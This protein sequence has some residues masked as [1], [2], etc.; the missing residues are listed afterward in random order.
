MLATG[1]GLVFSGGT[2]DR[3]FRAFDATSGA[4]LWQFPTSSGVIG[5]PVSFTVDGKQYVAVQSGWGIDSRTMQSRLTRL[6]PGKFPEV[7]EGGTVW[8]FAVK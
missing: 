7:P 3:M 6:M 1:G 5:Q 4:V 8:V 2:D